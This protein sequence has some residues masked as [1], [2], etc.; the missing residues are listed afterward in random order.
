VDDL[1]SGRLE[2]LSGLG[3]GDPGSGAPVE[4]FRGD[5]RDA[6]LMRSAVRGAHG[7]FHEAAQVSVPASVR[8]PVLSY[9]INVLGTLTVLEAARAE[10]VPKLVFAASS[11]AYGDDPQL[12]KVEDM[13]PRPLSPYA[14]GKLAG[15]ALL[16][17][18]G[19]CYGLE[20]VAL[21]YFAYAGVRAERRLC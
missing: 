12:P 9:G 13:P 17:V 15:E 8:D 1:S 3:T 11:A 5:V 2:S 18:W 10:G 16:A 7:V 6:E 19:R 4:L 21:R 20:T 14:S